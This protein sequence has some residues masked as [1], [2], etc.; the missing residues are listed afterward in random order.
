[1]IEVGR[2]RENVQLKTIKPATTVT[3]KIQPRIKKMLKRN[4]YSAR[5]F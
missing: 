2:G 1:M 3:N 5:Q 4:E